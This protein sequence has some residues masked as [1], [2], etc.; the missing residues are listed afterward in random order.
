[1]VISVLKYDREWFEVLW[2]VFRI[3]VDIVLKYG[4]YWYE[5]W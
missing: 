3:M 1:M 2:I 5:L 4:G